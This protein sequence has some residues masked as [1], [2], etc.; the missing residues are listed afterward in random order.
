MGSPRH[1]F[2][3]GDLASIVVVPEKPL[4]G[5]PWVW[6]GEF[7]GAFRRGRCRTRQS[8][9]APSRM[10]RAPDLFGSPQGAEAWEKFHAAMTGDVRPA[11]E[12]RLHRT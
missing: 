11:R 9:L 2:K 8:R 1:D 5:R 12:A 10:C 4:P 3:V 6:R 7:F